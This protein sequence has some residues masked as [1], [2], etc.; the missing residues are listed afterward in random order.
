LTSAP[1]EEG[2]PKKKVTESEIQR[3][4]RIRPPFQ[5]IWEMLTKKKGHDGK[6]APDCLRGRQTQRAP[7]KN[8][9]LLIWPVPLLFSGVKKV[10]G[11][12]QSPKTEFGAQNGG[13]TYPSI[14]NFLL[15]KKNIL[16]W[17]KN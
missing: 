15:I 7:W 4:S 11:S 5:Q 2:E 10:K 14:G 6:R 12:L 13:V 17:I 8:S 3:S 9:H 1:K 16:Y